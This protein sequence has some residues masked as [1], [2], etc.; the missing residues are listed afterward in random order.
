LLAR[1]EEI[2]NIEVRSQPRQIVLETPSQKNPS[3]KR[4]GGVIQ[5]ASPEFRPQCRQKKKKVLNTVPD[6]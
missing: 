4:A 6:L 5:G 1:E 3:Q 2:R